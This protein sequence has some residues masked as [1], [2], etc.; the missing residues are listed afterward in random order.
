MSYT[1]RFSQLATEDLTEILGWYKEQN[2]EGLHRQF[3]E[4]TSKVLK[5]LEINPQSNA[6]VHNNVRQAL[7]KK[8]P[9]K[10]LYTFDNAIV[11]VLVIAVIHQ[12]RDPKIWKGRI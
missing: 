2:V 7:L 3:I 9:Y 12:K 5:R 10:I 11:E 8:F 6:I 4:A 1:I